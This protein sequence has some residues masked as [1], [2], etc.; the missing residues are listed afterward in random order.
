[1]LISTLDNIA[2]EMFFRHFTIKTAIFKILLITKHERMPKTS[3]T[4]VLFN[5]LNTE[6]NQDFSIRKNKKVINP[7]GIAMKIIFISKGLLILN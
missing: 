5:P 7:I 1:M 4:P 6:I 3:E 2:F